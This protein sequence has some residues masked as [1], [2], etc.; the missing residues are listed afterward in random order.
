M[1]F[2]V[3]APHS[4]EY[5]F[6]RVLKWDIEVGEELLETL[7]FLY[8]LESENIGVHVV[9]SK[10]KIPGNRFDFFQ[11][12][13]KSW[14]SVEIRSVS[15]GILCNNL[16]LPNS[17]RKHRLYFFYYI[18]HLSTRL[19]PTNLR[20]DTEGTAII[21]TF[22]YLQVLVPEWSMD[23]RPHFVS[24]PD[25]RTLIVLLGFPSDDFEIF[26]EFLLLRLFHSHL[27]SHDSAHID[28]DG[29]P[30]QESLDGRVADE[31]NYRMEVLE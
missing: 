29:F 28:P 18:L 16:D 14:F 7:Q 3:V 23:I 27:R 2:V 5:S 25:E 26:R 17:V 21:A 31:R 30:E 24:T 12:F 1:C 15:S 22:G 9:Q 8:M 4:F 19:L 13:K 11:E 6:A 10:F 20:D